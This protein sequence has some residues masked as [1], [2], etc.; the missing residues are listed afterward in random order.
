MADSGMVIESTRALP[1]LFRGPT[2][3]SG[4]Y[5][6][7]V[8][9]AVPP[10]LAGT[11][12]RTAPA[13][14][15]V[16]GWSAAHW[17]DAQGMLYA[18]DV[19]GAGVAFRHR[20]L[21]SEIRRELDAGEVKRPGFGTAMKRPWWR[22]LTRPVPVAPDN[23]NVNI[24]PRGDA[25]AALTETP[26]QLVID[27]AT[28]AV[29]GVHR[30][31]DALGDV[32]MTAHPV[33]DPARRR[34]VDVATALAGRPALHVVE[35]DADGGARTVVATWHPKRV[36]YVHAFGVTARAVVL[37]AHPMTVNPLEM[38]WSERGYI[39]H[40]RWEGAE[41]MRL[42][43]IDRA[44][45]AAREVEAPTGFV[46]HVIDAFDDGDDV[47]V[48]AL[49]Y[50]D[51]SVIDAL[52]IER[53]ARGEDFT[54][55]ARPTRYR[56]RPNAARAEVEAL[57][58]EGFEFPAIDRRRVG[59][60]RRFVWGAAATLGANA[61]STLMCLDAHE[62]VTRRYDEP[63]VVFGEPVFVARPGAQGEGDGV[64][65]S[66]GSDGARAALVGVDA[67]TLTRVFR[68]SVPVPVPL[69]FHGGFV[70]AK[71]TAVAG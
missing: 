25:L 33:F 41:P 22:R 49:T 3:A 36:P 10:W 12:V 53:L 45:G 11:L 59:P 52:R 16:G 47:V 64:I 61:R 19:G 30:W 69:G 4:A 71:T 2:E 21:E 70:R 66:V 14:F 18:F 68:A 32:S 51:A 55:A 9:G 6:A 38:L 43:V 15:T 23:T 24:V 62:G 50:P 37:L 27:P 8:E 60:A 39:D 34:W 44:T 29:R 35:H 67:R 20:D 48:D 46:F 5:A 54:V 26:Y 56:V 57:G 63:G 1:W 13:R 7:D 65:L 28:L 42:V 31:P 17:F 58:A 40:F